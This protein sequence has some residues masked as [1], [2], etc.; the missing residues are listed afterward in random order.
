[1][2]T[3]QT[4]KAAA[5]TILRAA[6]LMAQRAQAVID[7]VGDGTPWLTA[8]ELDGMEAP[9]SELNPED[10][11]HIAGISPAFALDVADWLRA[12]GE[13]LRDSGDFGSCDEPAGIR[14]ALR[15]AQ[16]YLGGAA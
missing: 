12:C 15:I 2:T 6:E 10:G 1:M 13:E 5:E 7:A 3:I 9:T 4:G 16:I 11:E 8:A 14:R